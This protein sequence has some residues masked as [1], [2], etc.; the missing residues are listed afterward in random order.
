MLL[1]LGAKKCLFRFVQIVYL[2]IRGVQC[3]HFFKKAK[4]KAPIYDKNMDRSFPFHD[5]TSETV[6]F[7]EK[8]FIAGESCMVPWSQ[9]FFFL[10]RLA[11]NLALR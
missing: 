9:R 4:I 11:G 7:L 1:A 2:E 5:K 3:I 10:F 6:R 8:I